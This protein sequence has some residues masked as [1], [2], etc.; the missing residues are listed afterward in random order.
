MRL[1]SIPHRLPEL[2][3]PTRRVVATLG[4]KK[5]FPRQIHPL[6]FSGVL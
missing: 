5:L 4:T 1:Q 2:S 6:T 3:S